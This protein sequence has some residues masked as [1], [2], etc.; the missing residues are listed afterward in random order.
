MWKLGNVKPWNHLVGLEKLLQGKTDGLVMNQKRIDLRQQPL[1]P[2]VLM[3]TLAFKYQGKLYFEDI[4]KKKLNSR[5]SST[6]AYIKKNKMSWLKLS[7]EHV[8]WTEEQLDCVHFSNESKL[9]GCDGR[10]FVRRS[11]KERYSP[12]CTKSR[13]KFGKGYV[14]VFG[15][16]S[17]VGTGPLV[18]QH[19]KINPNVYKEILKKHVFLNLRIAINETAVFWQNNDL[20]HTAMSVKTFLSGEDITVMECPA[21][22]P[23]MDPIENIWKLLKQLRKRIQETPKNYGRIWKENGRK[24]PLMDARN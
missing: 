14:I 24:Y 22:S 4:I 23:E 13:V 7:T 11:P 8:I 16:I 20:C 15:M 21:L 9:F 2:K 6:K 19:G 5:V 12:Q 3:L 1:F 18:K 17:A 10:R